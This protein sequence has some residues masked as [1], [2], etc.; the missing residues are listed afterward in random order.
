MISTPIDNSQTNLDAP[1]SHIVQVE[2]IKDFEKITKKRNFPTALTF[3]FKNI[4][5]TY[6]FKSSS[7]AKACI[8]Q[9]RSHFNKLREKSLI[10]VAP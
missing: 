8:I 2:K 3:Y 1:V 6:V 7:E 9:L 10:A 5:F 4:N